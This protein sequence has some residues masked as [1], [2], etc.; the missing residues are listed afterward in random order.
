MLDARCWMLVSSH[1]SKR[2][3]LEESGRSHKPKLLLYEKFSGGLR[4][5]V[6]ITFRTQICDDIGRKRVFSEQ[7]FW[8][9]NG[10]FT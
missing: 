7:G 10:G 8:V 9:L 1:H 3:A 6:V 5:M 2:E 4:F